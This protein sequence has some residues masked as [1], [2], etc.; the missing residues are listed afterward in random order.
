MHFS[1]AGATLLS[2]GFPLDS[3]PGHDGI[4]KGCLGGN[5]LLE[6]PSSSRSSVAHH[7][8]SLLILLLE[9]WKVEM[10]DIRS[11]SEDSWSV[12]FASRVLVASSMLDMEA[13]K[14]VSNGASA[15]CL[16]RVGW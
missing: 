3:T 5:E 2:A 6:S 15:H 11:V 4:R 7:R 13:S 8:Q 9:L 10:E 12:A 14:S 1:C 16:D